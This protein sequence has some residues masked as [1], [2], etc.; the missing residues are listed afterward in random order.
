MPRFLVHAVAGT[1]GAGILYAALPMFLAMGLNALWPFGLDALTAT[2]QIK[3]FGVACVAVL[4][5]MTAFSVT[6]SSRRMFFAATDGRPA[7]FC[8]VGSGLRAERIYKNRSLYALF[9]ALVSAIVAAALA[10]YSAKQATS[11]FAIPVLC[12]CLLTVAASLAAIEL[13]DL[14]RTVRLTLYV[15]D[16]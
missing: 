12:L 4:V 3:M 16:A 5:P 14:R 10:A 8:R 2:T 9:T 6:R 15:G 11:S 7:L 13:N 1:F